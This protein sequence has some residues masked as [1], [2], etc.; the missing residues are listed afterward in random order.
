MNSRMYKSLLILLI[1]QLS[2]LSA[3]RPNNAQKMYPEAVQGVL[4]LADWDLTKD[5]PADLRG[6]F[7]FYW[8]QLL[9][10]I[11][12]SKAAPPQGKSYIKVPSYWNNFEIEGLKVPGDGYATYRLII[13]LDA[14][15]EPL[16]LRLSEISTAY[17]LF[18]NGQKVTSVGSTGKTHET[19][20]PGFF[21]HDVDFEP[22]AN[23]L[24][25]I[26]HVSNFH[27]RRGGVWEII[28]LGT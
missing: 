9:D 24:D 17:T 3:C 21:R 13:L 14:P 20:I 25:I 15:K 16:A 2:F 23:Q 19:T 10:P 6:E 8:M 4:D 11:E 5:G 27:H 1:L 26:I 12:F 18:L 22:T 28:Q 7:E